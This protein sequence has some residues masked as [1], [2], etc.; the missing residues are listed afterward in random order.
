MNASYA[1]P[2]SE[3]FAQ[4]G[5]QPFGAAGAPAQTTL[6]AN[7]SRWVGIASVALMGI[8]TLM[9]LLGALQGDRGDALAG[10]GILMAIPPLA[11]GPTALVMGIIALINVKTAETPDG[12]R[13]AI[14]GIATGAA[15]LVLCCAIGVM[16]GYFGSNER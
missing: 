3:P 9:V 10:F 12:R 5:S 8:G 6:L 7:A 15:T 1:R 14:L 2:S 11:S 13:H 4:P 16:A